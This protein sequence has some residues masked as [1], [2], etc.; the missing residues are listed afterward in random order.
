M[1]AETANAAASLESLLQHRWGFVE[2]TSW[3]S[4]DKTQAAGQVKGSPL[5]SPDSQSPPLELFAASIT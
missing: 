4:L 1:G 2:A 3:G 5:D